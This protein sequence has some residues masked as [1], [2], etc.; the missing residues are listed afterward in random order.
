MAKFKR[1]EYVII[2]GRGV[3]RNYTYSYERAKEFA[4]CVRRQC[5]VSKIRW[6][7]KDMGIVKEETFFNNEEEQ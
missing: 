2:D 4:N 5:G 3:E 7:D 6:L 1:T